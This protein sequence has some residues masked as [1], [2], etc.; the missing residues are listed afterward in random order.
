MQVE[1]RVAGPGDLDALTAIMATLKMGDVRDFRNFL[2]AVIDDRAFDRISAA[3]QQARQDPDLT[4]VAG[5][6]ANR[7]QQ[8]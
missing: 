3:L 1:P 5:G 8:A 7:Q 4:L 2:G 6:E